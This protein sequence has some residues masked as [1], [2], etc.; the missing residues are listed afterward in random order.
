MGAKDTIVRGWKIEFLKVEE[1]EK[2]CKCTEL[3]RK[4]AENM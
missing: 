1:W 4:P 3:E 2:V